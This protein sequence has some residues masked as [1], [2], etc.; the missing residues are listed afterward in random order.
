MFTL[1]TKLI[2]RNVKQVETEKMI[3]F[4]YRMSMYIGDITKDNIVS[5]MH[6]VDFGKQSDPYWTK[7]LS[8]FILHEY[9]MEEKAMGWQYLIGLWSKRK[10]ITW[11][12]GFKELML[13]MIDKSDS[14]PFT[15]KMKNWINKIEN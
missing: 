11:E 9:K 5:F 12:E 13:E 14:I 1:K 2:P 7:L 10:G 15:I 8:E 3:H 4:L 6:G